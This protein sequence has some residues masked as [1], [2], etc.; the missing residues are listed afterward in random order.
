RNG[1]GSAPNARTGARRPPAPRPSP[2]SPAMGTTTWWLRIA[3]ARTASLLGSRCNAATASGARPVIRPGKRPGDSRSGPGIK[4]SSPT[5]SG[6]PRAPRRARS[7]RRS[8]QCERSALLRGVPSE[9]DL[10]AIPRRRDLDPVIG[11]RDLLEPARLVEQR[12]DPL[13][14]EDRLV[15]VE[16][17]PPGAR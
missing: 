16:A 14:V 4:M 7:H 17:Q 6:R 12:G 9:D 5:P 8:D 15:M 2:S 1:S 10:Q 11:A 13:V 3:W